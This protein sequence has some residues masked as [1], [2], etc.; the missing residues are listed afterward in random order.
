QAGRPG[1]PGIRRF[2]H[3]DVELLVG[4]VYEITAV[5]GDEPEPGIFERAI[6][7][8]IEVMRGLNDRRF[9]LDTCDVLERKLLYGPE[10]D[11]TA[12]PDHKAVIGI[13]AQEQRHA[14]DQHLGGEVAGGRRIGLSVDFQDA[15]V[16]LALNYDSGAYAFFV[17]GSLALTSLGKVIVEFLTACPGHLRRITIDPA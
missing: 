1:K 6:V 10:G 8:V 14:A 5:V 2:G 4:G 3:D 7:D 16:T 12:Q 11:S 15:V 13:L 9:Q 17:E